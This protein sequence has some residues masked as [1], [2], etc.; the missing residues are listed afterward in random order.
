[1]RAFLILRDI[2]S[3]YFKYAETLKDKYLVEY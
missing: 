1:M 3:L 2:F